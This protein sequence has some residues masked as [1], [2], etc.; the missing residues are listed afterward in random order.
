M[1]TWS[2]FHLY[3]Q[4]GLIEET[5]TTLAWLEFSINVQEQNERT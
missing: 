5:Y 4:T 2:V 1:V 3:G